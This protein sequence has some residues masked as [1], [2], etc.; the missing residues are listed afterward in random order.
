V[1]IELLVVAQQTLVDVAGDQLRRSVLH[2]AE[3]QP[4]GL[5]L[6]DGI[7]RAARLAL[8]KHVQRHSGDRQAKA[9]GSH[10]DHLAAFH[11]VGLLAG[12]R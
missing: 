7:E 10:L 4:G 8:G 5:R 12:S 3:H 6:H 1:G 2:D 9:C 11:G